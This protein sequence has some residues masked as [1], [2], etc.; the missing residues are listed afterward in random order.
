MNLKKIGTFVAVICS[1]CIFSAI[2]P[3]YIAYADE[4]TNIVLEGNADGIVTV[5][6]KSNFLQKENMMPG[7]TVKGEI[8]LK[9]NYDY[10]YDIYIRAEDREKK[11]DVSFLDKLKLKI[12]LNDKELYNGSL[13]GGEEMSEY[14]FLGTINPGKSVVLKAVVT[15][16]GKTVGNEYKNNYASVDWIF[17][18]TRTE[19]LGDNEFENEDENGTEEG[20]LGDVEMLI[21]TG[22]KY[23][24]IVMP[25]IMLIVISCAVI[26]VCTKRGKA[27][28]EK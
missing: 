23:N 10:P 19:V 16:D 3:N 5:P 22:D 26:L 4:S 13:D 8:L 21:K 12:S 11:S 2:S 17:T 9:N 25:I 28:N 27:L 18:A 7:D 15:L 24:K 14:I 20:V 6:N 1:F